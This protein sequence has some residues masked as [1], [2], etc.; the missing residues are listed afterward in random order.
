M[1]LFEKISINDAKKEHP[2]NLGLGRSYI[3]Y[4]VGIEVICRCHSDSSGAKS[5]TKNS[6]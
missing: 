3:F 4:L 6:M 5:I 2:E 1:R